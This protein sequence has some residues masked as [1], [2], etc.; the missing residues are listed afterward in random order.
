M[1]RSDQ[2]TTQRRRRNTDALGGKRRRLAVEESTLDRE[3]F[4]YRFANDENGRLHQLTVNDDWDVV[5][6]RDG[7]AKADSVGI[8]AEVAAYAGTR[9]NGAPLRSVLLRKRKDLHEEDE[10]AKQR[11]VDDT[12]A[13]LRQA[14]PQEPGMYSPKSSQTT[15]AVRDR[16]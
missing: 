6:D 7:E 1:A 10:A 2:I 13:G 4:V 14:A 8:G 12:E 5:S 16:L 3:N 9:E 11:R 15:M